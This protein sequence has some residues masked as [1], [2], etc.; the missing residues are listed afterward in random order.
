LVC[1]NIEVLILKPL[2]VLLDLD[3]LHLD[4][5]LLNLDDF[6][7]GTPNVKEAN[8][9]HEILIFLVQDGVVQHIMYKE[10]YKL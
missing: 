7:N 8:G 3:A 9:L 6:F 2:V 5:V 10:I 1:K 4:F